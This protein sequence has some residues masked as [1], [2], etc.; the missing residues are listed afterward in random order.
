MNSKTPPSNI[1]V[2]QLKRSKY[3]SPEGKLEWLFDALKFGKAEKKI[4]KK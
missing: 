3:V 4:I 2:D 1:D